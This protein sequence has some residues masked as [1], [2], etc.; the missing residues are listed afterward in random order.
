[1]SDDFKP[2]S[3]SYSEITDSYELDDG[4][5]DKASALYFE[6]IKDHCVIRN[7]VVSRIHK[8]LLNFIESEKEFFI[9]EN[10]LNKLLKS[11]NVSYFKVTKSHAK[12]QYLVR[13]IDE[14]N[15]YFAYLFISHDKDND[16]Y[17]LH[18][19]LITEKNLETFTN[20]YEVKN[21]KQYLKDKNEVYIDWYLGKDSY[22]ELINSKIK[23]DV[24]HSL[25][26]SFYPAITEKYSIDMVDFI[27][28]FKESEESVLILTGMKGS[29]KTELIRHIAKQFNTD[30]TL[31]FNKDIMMSN[32]FYYE[33][34]TSTTSDLMIIEDADTLLS[35]RSDGNPV[36]DL[37]LNLSDG[38]IS[39]SKKKFIFT[40]N[41]PNLST[42][43]EALLRKGR[44][45]A[46]VEFEYLTEDQALVI[47]NQLELNPEEFFE[48]NGRKE[49]SLADIMAYS[50]STLTSKVKKVERSFGFGK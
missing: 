28:N 49:S 25:H 16:L 19:F 33:F 6:N 30:A 9:N 32:D 20:T 46:T 45:F 21:Y 48:M 2:I 3:V 23:L 10:N 38:L 34:F 8:N 26:N 29:G 27:E 50:N 43:D 41:L 4:P 42:I 36:M 44:C 13:V 40:S 11:E 24:Q 1:M 17:S 35:K 47:L 18:N 39:S 37:F 7:S 31:T 5:T 15:K 14:T 12:L 22:G